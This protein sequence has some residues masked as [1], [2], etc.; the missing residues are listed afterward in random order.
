MQVPGCVGTLEG[1][2]DYCFDRNDVVPGV[3]TRVFNNGHPEALAGFL[4]ECEGDCDLDS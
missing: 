4:R 1:K 3:L 2:V